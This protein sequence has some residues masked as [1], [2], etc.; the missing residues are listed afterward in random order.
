VSLALEVMPPVSTVG[1]SGGIE[2]LGQGHIREDGGQLAGLRGVG[3][4]VSRAGHPLVAAGIKEAKVS[5]P[6]HSS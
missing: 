2:D 1:L 3:I 5:A 4:S 6:V